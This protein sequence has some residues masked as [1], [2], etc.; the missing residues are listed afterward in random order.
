MTGYAGKTPDLPELPLK[1]KV[2]LDHLAFREPGY[3]ASKKRQQSLG[4]EIRTQQEKLQQLKQEKE[5]LRQQCRK[6][7]DVAKRHSLKGRNQLLERPLRHIAPAVQQA[8]EDTVMDLDLATGQ[9]DD[10]VTLEGERIQ[11]QLKSIDTIIE[12]RKQD[13]ELE[14]LG[15]NE[16]EREIE[17]VESD[18]EKLNT[19]DSVNVEKDGEAD[20]ISD[21][22]SDGDPL[23]ELNVESK[24]EI[25][26]EKESSREVEN[27]INQETEKT[28]V[29][30]TEKV[31]NEET[32]GKTAEKETNG[33]QIGK[34]TD[35][36]KA[37]GKKKD[38]YEAKQRELQEQE[39]KRRERAKVLE[40]R[41]QK[42]KERELQD[43][44]EKRTEL[45]SQ[46]QNRA[47]AL[48]DAEDELKRLQNRRSQL[49]Q[50]QKNLREEQPERDHGQEEQERQRREHEQMTQRKQELEQQQ[51]REYGL[52]RLRADLQRAQVY[53]TRRYEYMDFESYDVYGDSRQFKEVDD[54][55]KKAEVLE[56]KLT[57][58]LR[59]KR[60]LEQVEDML[61]ALEREKAVEKRLGGP[62]ME[63]SAS[64]QAD[65]LSGNDLGIYKKLGPDQIRLLIVWPAQSDCYPLICTLRIEPLSTKVKPT[66][67]ALSYFW[68]TD[69]PD[70]RLYLLRGEP[71]GG[72]LDQN[73]WGSAAKHAMRIPI[74]NSLFRALLRLRRKTVPIALWVDV[75]CIN[76]E[77]KKEKTVQLRRMVDIYRM[78]KNV[79]IWLGE[80]DSKEY[81]NEAMEFI[82]KIMDFAMLDTLAK[83]KQQARKWYALS[84]LMRDRWFSRRWIVQEISLAK[85]ATLHCGGKSVQ[86]LDFVDAVSILVSNQEKIK[87]L[88]DFS[89]Y[90]EG[91]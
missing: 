66:Y 67:A 2:R 5:E 83:D 56:A 21:G 42:E 43:L 59:L 76:Q 64:F 73:N 61:H 90:R 28:P 79:C 33:G 24:V 23:G 74:R 36:K 4:G 70:A 77:D 15:G 47:D 18:I 40:Q 9:E 39:A 41:R 29:R 30:E 45:L 53:L 8:L 11:D 12:R 34:E 89:L 72:S 13:I 55:L 14:E 63:M 78:A 38:A 16:L 49:E 87:N 32:T 84:E 46:K 17:G 69:P 68:G 81:S 85:G 60:R 37:G 27:K 3:D 91:A 54:M 80:A 75:M 44:K 82:P 20:E 26:E 57:E 52:K 10:G 71:P 62:S 88:F 31:V 22:A 1:A 25:L 7:L 50:E 58:V 6:E 65:H 19:G 51:K 86:W 48:R 35:E